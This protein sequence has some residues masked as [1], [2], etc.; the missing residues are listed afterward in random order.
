M[1][2]VE[3]NFKILLIDDFETMIKIIRN[4]LDELG[5]HNIIT[6]RNGEI[7]WEVLNKERIDFIIS[8]WN[9]PIM[10][11]FELLKKVKASD[12]DFAHIPFLMVTA[13]AEKRHILD[14]VEE[15]VNQY[16]IKPFTSNTLKEKIASAIQHQDKILAKKER[17]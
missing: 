13:E 3:N 5:F 9:M 8:D 17:N 7:A 10:T 12:S 16:I 1:K 2:T 14:A 15:G 11:G 4:I 6:A